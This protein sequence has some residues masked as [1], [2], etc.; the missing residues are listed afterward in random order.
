MVAVLAVVVVLVAQW[1]RGQADVQQ[2]ILDFPG[3][4]ELPADTPAGIPVWLAWQHGLNAFFLLF[5]IRSGLQL[6]TG[7]RPS[8]FWKRNN[9]GLIRT[10]GEPVRVGITVWL[11]VAFDTLWIVNGLTYFVLLFATG[12]WMRVVPTSWDIVPNAVSAG[13]QYVSLDWPVEN[14]W[15]NYNA[16]QL[17]SYFVVIFVAAPLAIVTGI[18][19]MPGFAARFRSLDKAFPLSA[20][21]T[22]HFWLMLFFIAFIAVHV[23]LVLATGAQRNLNHMYAARDDGSWLGVILFAASLVVMAA[24]WFALHP[25]VVKKLASLTGTVISR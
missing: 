3:Q 23:F 18:R 7:G 24:T 4:S 21:R 22:L 2:F 17:L 9:T 6:R 19:L 5:I 25:V 1:L 12:Q 15:V 16:L 10:K 13:L 20:A 14:G 11:H 8:T